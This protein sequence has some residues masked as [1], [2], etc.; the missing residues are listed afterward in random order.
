MDKFNIRVHGLKYIQMKRT[1]N[2]R[3]SITW[4]FLQAETDLRF[5]D[6]VAGNLAWIEI[7]SGEVKW[8]P[9]MSRTGSRSTCFHTISHDYRRLVEETLMG[10]GFM[11]PLVAEW[12]EQ[13]AVAEQ[14][15]FLPEQPSAEA[16]LKIT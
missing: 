1:V 5:S 10:S 7:S 6:T 3:F 4:E 2:L 9:H 15:T 12:H 11:K 16:E 14:D 13:Q 8:T